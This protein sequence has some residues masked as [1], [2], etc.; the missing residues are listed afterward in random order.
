MHIKAAAGSALLH[1]VAVLLLWWAGQPEGRMIASSPLELGVE[2]AIEVN[3]ADLPARQTPPTPGL[4]INNEA[5]AGD[6]SGLPRPQA[7]SIAEPQNRPQPETP[8]TPILRPNPAHPTRLKPPIAVQVTS[9]HDLTQPHSTST[10]QSVQ[11][12]EGSGGAPDEQA[13]NRQQGGGQTEQAG[14]SLGSAAT[15][16]P[17]YPW[18]ARRR[19]QEGRV[20]IRLSV[21]EYGHPIKATI[22]TSSGNASLDQAALKTLKRWRLTPARRLGVAVTA[23]IDV[24]IRFQLQ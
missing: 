15:P 24:P 8:P 16:L 2:V 14:Y 12:S 18:S 20:I 4:T 19:G 23:Q 5:V 1:G 17:D 6:P 7:M 21:D 10:S 13:H 22:L 11:V 9:R 3:L